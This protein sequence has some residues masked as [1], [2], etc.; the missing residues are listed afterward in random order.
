MKLVICLMGYQC[1]GVYVIENYLMEAYGIKKYKGYTTRKRRKAEEH[2]LYH[3]VDLD[4]MME[5]DNQLSTLREYKGDFFARKLSDI[6]KGISVCVIDYLG[7]LELKEKVFT[8]PIFLERA[9]KNRY[10]YCEMKQAIEHNE[11]IRRDLHDKIQFDVLHSDD[12]VIKI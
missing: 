12:D 7:Y 1:S 4:T 11:F 2:D 5:L 3:F 9:L 8:L 10:I 6:P